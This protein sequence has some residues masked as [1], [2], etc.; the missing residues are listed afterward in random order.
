MISGG[1]LFC[2]GEF[3]CTTKTVCAD[4]VLIERSVV[5]NRA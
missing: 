2:F 3:C 1:G 5:F 4:A